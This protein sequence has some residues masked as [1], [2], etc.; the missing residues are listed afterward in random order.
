MR[1]IISLLLIFIFLVSSAQAATLTVGS[2]AKYKTIQSAVNAAKTGDTI[3]VNLGTY[4]EYVTVKGKDLIFQGQKVGTTYKYPSV[5]RF[6]FSASDPSTRANYNIGSGDINGFKILKGVYYEYGMG[7]K[8]TIRNNYFYNSGI[9]IA[10]F[11]NSENNIINNK[12][13]GNYD[14]YGVSLFESY[15]NTITGNT[16]DK[17]KV[18]L[19]LGDCVTCKTITKNTFSSCKVGVQCYAIPDV[20]IGNTYKGNTKNINVIP[21]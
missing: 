1:K 2:A 15:D 21:V 3:Y 7:G 5:Y 4:K 19:D 10:G 18:G 17:A 14:Y 12:F 8:N 9:S 20:L 13:T 11:T 6:V 16:F